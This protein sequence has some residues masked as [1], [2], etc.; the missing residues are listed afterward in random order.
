V[1]ERKVNR[2]LVD[3]KDF[4][5]S[6]P[7][8]ATRNLPANIIDKVQ[9]LDDKDEAELHPDKLPIDLGQVINLKLK[10]S[11]K[12]GWFGKTYA[13][14]GTEDKYEAGAIVNLFRDTFQVSLIGF[15]NNVDRAGFRLDDIRTLAGFDRSGLDNYTISERGLNVNGISFG[16]QGEGISKTSGAGIN[17]NHVL[18]NGLTLNTQYFFGRSVNDIAELYNQQQFL[19]DSVINIRSR[20]NEVRASNSHR[21]GLGLKGKLNETSRIA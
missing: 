8:M 3:G 11:I 4:F 10:K 17:L 9:V 13:G 7:R 21:I 19:G 15:S 18:K 16:G 6:D 14:A 5:G 12:K 20:R 1:N 2:L